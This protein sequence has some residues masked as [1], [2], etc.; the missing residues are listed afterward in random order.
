MAVTA[1]HD[2]CEAGALAGMLA[3]RS[4][5]GLTAASYANLIEEA[6]AIADEFITVNTASGAALADGDKASMSA[7]V[8]AVASGVLMGRPAI[9]EVQP[10][11]AASYVTV[12][13]QIY[14]ISAEAKANG[15]LT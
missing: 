11:V 13:T 7:V 3:G 5:G 8:G 1:I 4:G 6:Q 9:T 12:A 15:G 2:A 10:P 14:A